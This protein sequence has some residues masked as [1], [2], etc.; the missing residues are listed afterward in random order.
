MVKEHKPPQ[1]RSGSPAWIRVADETVTAACHC[2][3]TGELFLG[4]ESGEVV[5]FRPTDGRVATLP[6]C[7]GAVIRSLTADPDGR[8]LVAAQGDANGHWVL[9]HWTKRTAGAYELTSSAQRSHGA[10]EYWLT[11]VI[12]DANGSSVFAAWDG[13]SLDLYGEMLHF[14]ERSTLPF[15]PE[16]LTAALLLPSA[17][18]LPEADRT[19][20][21]TSS[22]SLPE[23][24]EAPPAFATLLIAGPTV[25]AQAPAWNGRHRA[26]LGWAPALWAGV[27]PT[28][29]PLSWWLRDPQH[30]EL[31]GMHED[32]A[33]CWSL[34]LFYDGVLH[35]LA[36]HISREVGYRAVTLVRSGLLAAVSPS[37]IDWL[38]VGPRG[39]SLWTST[40]LASPQPVA[41]FASLVTN[42]V[43][44]VCT[45][46]EI[47][48]VPVPG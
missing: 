28:P 34:L 12:S 46:G 39:F 13:R 26:N 35:N 27:G 40:W 33:V 11:P 14:W 19:P 17:S 45:D 31:V 3:A 4:L 7:G 37:R 1:P 47:V 30:G 20:V 16:D 38:R 25:W 21:V 8:F 36:T 43:L 18:A 42:E 10:G 6:T 9:T 24:V 22:A 5:Y 23:P 29:A 44:V 2:S 32:G 15:P 41:C 48:R